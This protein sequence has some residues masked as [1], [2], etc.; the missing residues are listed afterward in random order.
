LG[1]R[2]L[3]DC[4]HNAEGALALADHLADQ[5]VLYHLLF[6]CLDDKPVEAMADMLWPKVGNVAVCPLDD[7][8]AMPLER[9][10]AAFPECQSATSVHEALTLLPDP[11][12]VAGSVRLAGE[13]LAAAEEPT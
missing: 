3:V 12:V 9:L 11:V 10:R 8:R 6:S 4:A 1:R 7:D 2:I 5:P 13:L